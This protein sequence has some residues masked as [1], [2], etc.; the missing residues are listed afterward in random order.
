MITE[1]SIEQV[2]I[3]QEKVKKPESIVREKAISMNSKRV[4]VITG[5]RRCGKSTFLH[6]LNKN[7][8]TLSINFEDTRLEGFELID[9]NKVEKIAIRR[10]KQIILFDE[11]QNINGWEKYVRSANERGIQIQIT[12]SNAS[13]LS[14]E[15]GTHLTGR[16]QQVELYPFDYNEF[17]KYTQQAI[18]IKSFMNFIEMGGFPEYLLE[19]NLEYLQTLLRDIIMRDIAVRRGIKNEHYLIRL[20]VHIMSNTGKEF[21]YNNISKT[22][23]I[24]S[25]RTVIDY[26]DYLQES[27]LIELIP[28]FS[29][30][31]HQQQANPKKAYAIDTALAKANSLSF[32]KDSGRMLENAVFIHLRRNYSDICFF[33]NE[34]A[35]CDFLIKLNEEIIQVIQVCFNVNEDN[36]KRELSGLKEAMVATKCSNGIIITLDQDDELDGISLIPAWKW[37]GKCV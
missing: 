19:K 21:S 5:I 10:K 22:L 6:Q 8:Q 13:M 30:S 32:N 1:S 4:L 3:A 33:R 9:F 37:M 2:I 18:G 16:Y 12:G 28:R 23:E 24:K 35:E 36:I 25:V 26:C 7:E 27:Y 11:V 17:L 15:L 29:Y 34:K 14:R 31:I 20:A